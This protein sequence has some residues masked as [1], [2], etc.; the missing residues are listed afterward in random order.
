MRTLMRTVA[1]GAALG[2]PPAAPAIAQLVLPQPPL[3]VT[4]STQQMTVSWDEVAPD[5]GRAV[6]NVATQYGDPPPSDEVISAMTIAGG[7]VRDCDYR[8]TITKIPFDPSFGL[9][10]K[11]VY[12]IATN[13]TGTGAPVAQDTLD[14]FEPDVDYPFAPNIAGNLTIR[15][16]PNVASAAALGNVPVTTGGLYAGR[17]ERA[18]YLARAVNSVASL[19]DTLLVQVRGPLAATIPQVDTLHVTVPD[20]PYAIMDGMTLS[21][22]QVPAGGSGAPGDSTVWSVHHLFPATGRIIADLEAFEGYHLWRADVANLDDFYL[23]G[24]IAPCESKEVF[25]RLDQNQI[26]ETDLTLSYDEQNRRF[27]LADTGIHDDFPY[28]YALSTFDRQF[29]GNVQNAT[30]EGVLSKSEVFY[31]ARTAR[32]PNTEVYV[33]PNP[34]KRTADWDEGGP[35]VVFANLP[36]PCTIRIFTAATDHVATL[37]H[38][39]PGEAR[40]TSPTS[41]T[42][43]LKTDRSQ[44]IV[45]G[46]YIWY[47]EGET[48][49]QVGKMIVVR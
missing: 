9:N 17:S 48:F 16:E 14:L 47:I 36:N 32:D 26:D 12:R 38:R 49:Q 20:S 30:T 1:A 39:Y 2:L 23:L 8:L 3:E 11:L 31:P 18:D 44:D 10:V 21:F 37:Q 28:R 40:S 22:A 19:A 33:V 29:L 42:W 27:Q 41:A 45:P 25:V 34:Y 13:T 5:M 7:Y 15:F 24:E 6:S 35:K 4:P 46:I 43:N